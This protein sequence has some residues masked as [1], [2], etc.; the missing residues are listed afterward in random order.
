MTRPGHDLVAADLYSGP[1]GDFIARRDAHA[2]ELRAAGDREAASAVKSLRK[3]SRMAW[4]LNRVVHRQPDAMSSIDAAVAGY[5]D[6]HAGAGDV[7]AAMT[8]LRGSVRDFAVLAAD[9]ARTAEFKLDEGDIANA[10]LAVL[11]NPDS[12]RELRAGRMADVPEAGGLDF[13]SNLPTRPMLVVSEPAGSPSE[14][15]PAEADALRERVRLAVTAFEA[16]RSNVAEAEAALA[17]SEAAVAA[18]QAR[19]RDAQSELTSAQQQREFARRTKEAAAA[20][21]READAARADA[22]RQLGQLDSR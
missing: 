12:Y 15:D 20:G 14:V 13:L 2:K 4:A 8:A 21:L 11:G 9:A 7:R 6:A 3:P 5:L 19:V 18:A 16:A 10:I 1:L 22:E 17:E